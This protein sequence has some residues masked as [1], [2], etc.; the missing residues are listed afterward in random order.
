MTSSP[1]ADR[2]REWAM[3]SA[4]WSVSRSANLYQ[5]D[6]WGAGFFDTN[7]QGHVVAITDGVNS[8]NFV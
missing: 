5:V 8:Y 1:R 2:K 4:D 3:S 7:E 6:G